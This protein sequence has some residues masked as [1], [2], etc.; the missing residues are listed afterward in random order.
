MRRCCLSD[1][2]CGLEQREGT[3][4]WQYFPPGTSQPPAHSCVPLAKLKQKSE[5]KRGHS[6][7]SHRPASRAV[8][9]SSN[10]R[11]QGKKSST[12]VKGRDF[13]VEDFNTCCKLAYSQCSS[14]F[15][16][17]PL[18]LSERSVFP[19]FS[20]PW[21]L[22][23]WPAWLIPSPQSGLWPLNTL[24]DAFADLVQDS[25]AFLLPITHL[26]FSVAQSVSEV[27]LSTFLFLHL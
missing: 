7:G 16:S 3:S 18:V 8:E 24:R 26:V 27:R 21:A 12:A 15:L 6:C 5:G 1:R 2:S 4:A 20:R 22:F 17:S 25:P 10:P 9:R 13:F 19:D 14:G 11:G 23:T